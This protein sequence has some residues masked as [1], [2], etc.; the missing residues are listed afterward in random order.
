MD[1]LFFRC[2]TT[3][4]K[5]DAGVETELGTL[6]KIRHETLRSR[7]PSCGQAHQW[8]VKDA[9]LTKAA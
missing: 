2:P 6:L 3:G 9:F 7:C 4:E 8:L 5:I 1:R